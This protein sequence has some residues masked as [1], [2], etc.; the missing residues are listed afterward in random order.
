MGHD[1]INGKRDL[2]LVFSYFF[3]MINCLVL[4]AENMEELDL[5]ELRFQG[6]YPRL[7]TKKSLICGF[8][9]AKKLFND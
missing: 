1:L 4:G 5:N 9:G 7:K 6:L 3:L 2:F 8:V